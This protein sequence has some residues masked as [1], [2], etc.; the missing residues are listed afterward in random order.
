MQVTS[1]NVW[2]LNSLGRKYVF[3]QILTFIG[4]IDVLCLREVKVVGFMLCTTLFVIWSKTMYFFLAI[5][6][7]KD[8]FLFW[9][10]RNLLMG[11][12]IP[13]SD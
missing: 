7:E 5:M 11:V 2:G 9:S 13:C 3:H 12:L 1:W 10:L 4:V 6:M 8:G